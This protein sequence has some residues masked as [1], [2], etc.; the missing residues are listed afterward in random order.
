[1]VGEEAENRLVGACISDFRDRIISCFMKEM[2]HRINDLPYCNDTTPGNDDSLVDESLPALRATSQNTAVRT[3]HLMLAIITLVA[4]LTIG[5]QMGI[6]E[7]MIQVYQTTTVALGNGDSL[8]D[9]SLPAQ[10]ATSQNIA[11]MT[12]HPMLAII[13]VVAGLTI[14]YQM[15]IIE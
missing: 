13:T 11:M 8:V 6:I 10:H 4:S 2:Q 5:Y 3:F 1:M 7:R 15:G 12:F 14:G 9:E